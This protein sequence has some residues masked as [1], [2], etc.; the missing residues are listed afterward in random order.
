[1]DHTQGRARDTEIKRFV[2]AQFGFR[3]TLRLHRAALGW[4]IL[5]APVN[6]LLAPVFLLIRVGALVA[7]LAKA[8]DLAR[9]LSQRNVFLET[10]VSRRVAR[11]VRGLTD[12]FVQKGSLPRVEPARRDRA[13]AEYVSTRGAVA[14]I[15]TI[16]IVLLVGIVLFRMVTPGIVSLAGP[17]TEMRALTR[18]VEGFPLGPFLGRAWFSVFPVR[19]GLLDLLATG[20]GLAVLA[21][22]VTTFAGVIADPFQVA[23]GTHRRRLSRMMDRLMRDEDG[24][25]LEREHLA[26]RAADLSDAAL[27]IWRIFR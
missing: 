22:L 14:E 5:R 26:A 1:M 20:A 12:E 13:I 16:M 25:G 11:A 21:S 18:A 4:D 9:W 2:R 8:P 23:T 10:E 24:P 17:V 7:R 15:V 3:G 6:L 27:S 19:F